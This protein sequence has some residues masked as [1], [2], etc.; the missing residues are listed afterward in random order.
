M[1]L[2]KFRKWK[3]EFQERIAEIDRTE[4]EL[5]K[6]VLA[7]AK[8][9]LERFYA[10]YEEKKKRNSKSVE[11]S[12]VGGD[13]TNFKGN[14]WEKVYKYI[15]MQT[16]ASLPPNQPTNGITLNGPAARMKEN[17]ANQ[18]AN[19]TA[20]KDASRMKVLLQELKNDPNAPVPASR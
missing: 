7:T 1:L 4:E 11:L 13:L 8:K 12:S 6:Q 17:L 10:E 16:T 15:D 3:S 14:S 20:Y 9:E 5:H 19:N 2:L 18:A